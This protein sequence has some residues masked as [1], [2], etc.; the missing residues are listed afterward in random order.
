VCGHLCYPALIKSEFTNETSLIFVKCENNLG[1]NSV[2]GFIINAQNVVGEIR[3]FNDQNISHFYN[4]YLSHLPHKDFLYMSYPTPRCDALEAVE[5]IRFNHTKDGHNGVYMHK[6]NIIK[7]MPLR[8]IGLEVYVKF[9]SFGEK[10]VSNGKMM[11]F[12]KG[13]NLKAIILGETDFEVNGE[14]S[15]QSMY[16]NK[17]TVSSVNRIDITQE[18]REQFYADIVKFFETYDRYR[19]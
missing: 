10:F 1:L 15:I 16:M 6:L 18:E 7:D 4:P 13:I 2:D 19:N 5:N 12:V 14:Y 3:V 8:A 17:H 11:K 9:Y